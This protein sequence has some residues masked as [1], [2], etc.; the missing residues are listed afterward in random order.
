MCV[1]IPVGAGSLNLQERFEAGWWFSPGSSVSSTN[2]C[3]RHDLIEIVLKVALNTIKQ[4]S[5]LTGSRLPNY[6]LEI[7]NKLTFLMLG[8]VPL[9]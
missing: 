3:E 1:S 6:N 9:Y 4:T 2:K 7:R 5:K 8:H